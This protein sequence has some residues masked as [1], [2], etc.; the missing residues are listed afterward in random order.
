M[1]DAPFSNRSISTIVFIDENVNWEGSRHN[2]TASDHIS[3]LNSIL[4]TLDLI[5]VIPSWQSL[6]LVFVARHHLQQLLLPGVIYGRFSDRASWASKHWTCQQNNL[7]TQY[8]LW[9]KHVVASS[10][11]YV[12]TAQW[13]SS[14]F[15]ACV[16]SFEQ[17]GVWALINVHDARQ[18]LMI[19]PE[20]A[21]WI[22]CLSHAYLD[23]Y[24]LI[25]YSM[26]WS[27]WIF[28][29]GMLHSIMSTDKSVFGC[30]ETHCLCCA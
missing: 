12:F 4:L 21:V 19:H 5:Y 26:F 6:E 14:E 1:N 23:I 16:N 30:S 29:E 10:M 17:F 25:W 22:L 27:V 13:I 3:I 28:L 11:H 18:C 9:K 20:S 8:N 7:W 2:A 24:K 15:Q